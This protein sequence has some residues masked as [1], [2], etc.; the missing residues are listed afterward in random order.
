M[1][2]YSSVATSERRYPRI[3]RW[4]CGILEMAEHPANA[5]FHCEQSGLTARPHAI[6]TDGTGWQL[7]QG[8]LSSKLQRTKVQTIGCRSLFRVQGSELF[9]HRL[10]GSEGRCDKPVQLDPLTRFNHICRIEPSFQDL[11]Y[12]ALAIHGAIAPGSG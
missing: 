8:W 5:I 11:A 3:R 6:A 4:T 7:K 9:G 12:C 2:Q 1:A 10:R